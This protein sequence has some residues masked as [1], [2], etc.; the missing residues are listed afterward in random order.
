MFVLVSLSVCTSYARNAIPP[1]IVNPR[2]VK[3]F[4]NKNAVLP[5]R[6]QAH[7]RCVYLISCF[8]LEFYYFSH[9]NGNYFNVADKILECIF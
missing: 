2:T 9:S 3:L 4:T 5:Y 8:A 7:L 1:N 6:I